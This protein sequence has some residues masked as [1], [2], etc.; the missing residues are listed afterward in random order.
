MV[1][2]AREPFRLSALLLYAAL[3]GCSATLTD[4]STAGLQSNGDYAFTDQEQL[5]SCEQLAARSA[6]IR[7]RMLQLSSSAMDK[8]HSEENTTL[9]A[10][11]RLVG[12]PPAEAPEIAE[13]N[14]LRAES[15]TIEAARVRKQCAAPVD[16]AGQKPLQDRPAAAPARS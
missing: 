12:Y 7:Q 15:T 6:E 16:A 13:Y 14:T 11:G 10:V 5:R 4:V 3:A 8:M 1:I 9:A 2:S